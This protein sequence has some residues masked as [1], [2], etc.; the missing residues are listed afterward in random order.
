MTSIKISI[1]L[2]TCDPR[3]C[4]RA[5]LRASV[6][7]YVSRCGPVC[8]CVFARA[9]VRDSIKLLIFFESFLLAAAAWEHISLHLLE[10]LS[11]IPV[12]HLTILHK[13]ASRANWHALSTPRSYRCRLRRMKIDVPGESMA[14]RRCSTPILLAAQLLHLRQ[15]TW[16]RKVWI[17]LWSRWRLQEACPRISFFT[18]VGSVW[19]SHLGPRRTPRGWEH[20]K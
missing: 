15:Q 8:V 7:T 9:L 19:Q 5:R 3:V 4:V 17:S 13:C 1:H 16:S 11:P 20:L 2:I 6:R 18:G 10:F 12:L 14:K